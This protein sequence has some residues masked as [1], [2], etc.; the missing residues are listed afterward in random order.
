MKARL[1]C[2]LV[3]A[4][5]GLVAWLLH[6]TTGSA[7]VARSVEQASLTAAVVVPPGEVEQAPLDP[8]E[9]SAVDRSA[10]QPSWTVRGVCKS[11]AGTPLDGVEITASA[12]TG[13]DVETP[14]ARSGSDGTFAFAAT[15]ELR[16][17][18]RKPGWRTRSVLVAPPTLP[19]TAR[20]LAPIFFEP[21]RGLRGRVRDRDGAPL[22]GLWICLEEDAGDVAQSIHKVRTRCDAQGR[23]AFAE[24]IPE[25]NY[26]ISLP[27]SGITLM[28]PMRFAVRAGDDRELEVT[29]LARLPRICGSVRDRRGEPVRADVEVRC[30]TTGV[31][32]G[33]TVTAKDGSFACAQVLPA[34]GPF[35]LRVAVAA[36][37]VHERANVTWGREDL[38]VVLPDHGRLRVLARDREGLPVTGGATLFVWPDPSS[39]VPTSTLHLEFDEQGCARSGD[40]TPGNYRLAIVHEDSA[41]VSAFAEAVVHPGAT[42]EVWVSLAPLRWLSV[43]VRRQ[44]GDPDPDARVAVMPA[45]AASTEWRFPMSPAHDALDTLRGVARRVDSKG[46]AELAIPQAWWGS[47]GV[48]V[49]VSNR[50]GEIVERL[51]PCGTAAVEIREAAAIEARVRVPESWR[52]LTEDMRLCASL[53]PPSRSG[54]PL[55]WRREGEEFV[56]SLPP[57][58]HSLSFSDGSVCSVRGVGSITVT[59]LGASVRWNPELEVHRCELVVA[60]LESC[61][62][63]TSLELLDPRSGAR[64]AMARCS[65]G[66]AELPA[67]RRGTFAWRVLRG[68]YWSED[69]QVC[70]GLCTI[71][72]TGQERVTLE[73]RQ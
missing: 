41:S 59:D 54:A 23:F 27:G 8:H 56:L 73:F 38:D 19:D 63:E 65:K 34:P 55:E 51:V 32:C 22:P 53:E 24:P 7:A 44:S 14:C 60:G 9:R 49:L 45:S 48:R 30:T 15:G 3:L 12:R 35:V 39:P 62:V 58:N 28:R 10:A 50:N 46:R 2:L 36:I 66:V 57:G 21:A 37:L 40:L 6:Q 70:A 33:T 43:S 5:C 4:L 52:A 71:A 26:A 11:D 31:L 18:L 17:R 13:S 20:V 67:T 69:S 47:A 25:A 72:S 29:A 64:V 68:S 1:A 61:T 42:D 16:L